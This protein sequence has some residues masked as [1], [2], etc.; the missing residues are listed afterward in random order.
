MNDIKMVQLKSLGFNFTDK[1]YLPENA[2]EFTIRFRQAPAREYRQ[3]SHDE[4]GILKSRGNTA[5]NWNNILVTENFSPN[6]VINNK[7]YGLNRIGDIDDVYLDFHDLHQP[8]GI[9]D[10]TIVSCDIGSNAALSNVNYISHYIVGDGAIILN[11]NEML[12]T[13]HAKF[14]NGIVKDGEDESVRIEIELS[15]ENGNRAV[16]PFDTMI[17]GDAWLWSKFRDDRA[18]M[19]RLKEITQNSFDSSRAYYG[20]I[21]EFTVIKNCRII[22][23]VKVG[24]HAYIKGCNKLKNLTVNS[25]LKSST[26]LGEGIELVNGIVG[27]GCRAF[28]GVKAIRFIMSDYSTLKYGARLIN[29]FLGS[30]STIS[31]CEVLNSLIFPGHEQHHNNSFLCAATLGGQSNIASGATIG[32]NHNSRAND[33]EIQASRGFWPGLCTSLKHNS[34]FSSFNLLAKGSYPSEINNPLPFSLLSNNETKGH[35]QIIPAY[36]FQY[37]LYALARNSWKYSVRDQRVVK[38]L[39]L[40]F[41]YLAPDTANEIV[42]AL[43]YLKKIV[44]ETDAFKDS[45]FT[46]E[47]EYLLAN[48]QLTIDVNTIENNRR[49]TQILKCGKAYK[50]YKEF[51]LFYLLRNTIT[52]CETFNVSLSALWEEYQDSEIDKWSSL[53]GQLIREKDLDDLKT[54]IK[55]G[56]LKTW[57]DIHQKYNDYSS[58]YEKSKLQHGLSLFK[59]YFKSLNM[60]DYIDSFIQTCR[61]ISEKTYE[62][63]AKD[64]TNPF[65]LSTYDNREEMEEVVGKL[66]DNSF[67][68]QIEDEMNELIKLAEKHLRRS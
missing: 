7:F 1:K 46:D 13:D 3:L 31:C 67:I 12:T 39:N 2:D 47:E 29:S 16:L 25:S 54:R 49:S 42:E 18:L 43:S 33:G 50:I 59:R 45:K 4:I 37:N 66:E 11:V 62:S 34:K 20:T 15:N 28:Y 68:I 21:G 8:A 57:D 35:L 41:D 53:G 9:Y 19:N 17:S 61:Y 24:S 40:K 32:S 14:G 23:D 6:R 56:E 60:E 22:K 27:Y 58:L 63:R 52:Y 65:R 10:S 30:N 48:P 55:N 38:Q 36:W 64:Y 44:T 26:Q 51:L 5:D